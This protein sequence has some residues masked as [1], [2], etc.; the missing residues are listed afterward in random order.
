MWVVDFQGRTESMDSPVVQGCYSLLV[1]S[2]LMTFGGVASTQISSPAV[3][4]S[5]GSLAHQQYLSF[6]RSAQAVEL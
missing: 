3:S 2:L 5:A 4:V 1:A 6:C